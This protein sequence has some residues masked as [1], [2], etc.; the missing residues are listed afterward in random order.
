MSAE[1]R[2]L[3]CSL[4]AEQDFQQVAASVRTGALFSGA[5]VLTAVGVFVL[6]VLNIC[7]PGD[8]NGLDY[9]AAF[10]RRWLQEP[11]RLVFI[12]KKKDRVVSVS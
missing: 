5:A 1:A 7:G 12:A 2:D 4:A 9:M 6:Q 8:Y 3:E 10:Y 11:G